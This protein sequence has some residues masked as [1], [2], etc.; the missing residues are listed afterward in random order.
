MPKRSTYSTTYVNALKAQL[1]RYFDVKKANLQ[2]AID[3][4]VQ[5]DVIDQHTVEALQH[6]SFMHTLFEPKTLLDH[7]I[8]NIVAEY[9]DKELFT[10]EHFGNNTGNAIDA[11]VQSLLNLYDITINKHKE[12]EK[13]AAF[14]T[15]ICKQLNYRG[16]S[17][18]QQKLANPYSVIVAHN[19]I[20][21]GFFNKHS[22]RI[23]RNAD[24]KLEAYIDSAPVGSYSNKANANDFRTADWHAMSFAYAIGDK[25]LDNPSFADIVA[26]WE[27]I[28]KK[29]DIM[30]LQSKH[31]LRS[32][33]GMYDRVIVKKCSCGCLF[34]AEYD[35]KAGSSSMNERIYNNAA[36]DEELGT[37]KHKLWGRRNYDALVD[38]LFD[39]EYTTAS[40]DDIWLSWAK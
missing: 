32:I 35:T 31:V 8:D 12:H 11:V 40:I 9:I 26:Q 13:L 37:L 22:L 19:R 29:L 27:H 39:C 10:I 20:W 21:I 24:G 17:D 6:L 4:A 23:L 2:S 15:S 18:E 14:I 38:F 36:K 25:L 5:N 33:I 3:I 34:E 1:Q 16:L 28:C 30:R 7:N